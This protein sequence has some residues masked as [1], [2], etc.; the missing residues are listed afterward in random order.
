MHLGRMLGPG[1]ENISL[2]LLSGFLSASGLPIQF[3][4]VPL[5]KESAYLGCLLPQE[6]VDLGPLLLLARGQGDAKSV[7]TLRLVSA[8][9]TVQVVQAYLLLLGWSRVWGN[10]TVC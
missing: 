10:G 8:D 3:L 5:G 2:K 9:T 7:G 1:M 4:P 6:N